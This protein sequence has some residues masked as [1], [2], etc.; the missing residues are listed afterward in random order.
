LLKY[1]QALKQQFTIELKNRFQLL[2]SENSSATEQYA[3]LVEAKDHAASTTLH[4]VRNNKSLV[5]SLGGGLK[6]SIFSLSSAE[7]RMCENI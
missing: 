3:V 2:H 6:I 7:R 4:V 1:D 5:A